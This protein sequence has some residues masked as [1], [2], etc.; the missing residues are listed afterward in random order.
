MSSKYEHY[1]MDILWSVKDE[2]YVVNVPELPEC[3]AS[4]ASREEAVD[5]A[6][7]A[8]KDW[9]DSH[10]AQGLPIPPPSLYVS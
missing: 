2:V 5:H 9:I 3:R 7:E 4:G 8:I 10:E 6:L 1:S